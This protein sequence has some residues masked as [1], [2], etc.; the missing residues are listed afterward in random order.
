MIKFRCSN[1]KKKFAVPDDYAGRRIRCNT[2]DQH[3]FV[4]KESN[5]DT[6][7]SAPGA[8]V[9]SKHSED[10]TEKTGDSYR[11]SPDPKVSVSISP[12]VSPPKPLS[13]DDQIITMNDLVNTQNSIPT[14]STE[15]KPMMFQMQSFHDYTL[16]E[17]ETEDPAPDEPTTKK[18]VSELHKHTRSEP[19][20]DRVE[21]ALGILSYISCIGPVFFIL[22]IIAAVFIASHNNSP[23]T[24]RAPF[25]E[26]ATGPIEGPTSLLAAFP[27]IRYTFYAFAGGISPLSLIASLFLV[28][29]FSYDMPKTLYFSIILHGLIFLNIFRG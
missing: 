6:P 7:T 11:F 16:P 20:T 13:S 23:R 25:A 1:C 29:R 14:G 28:F 19:K 24:M 22:I 9:A 8:F 21:Q 2:C 17:S 12:S 26:P 27:A 4:P 10:E 3:S 15:N 5:I 18:L